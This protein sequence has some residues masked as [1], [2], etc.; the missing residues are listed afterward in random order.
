MGMLDGLLGQ[1]LSGAAGQQRGDDDALSGMSG[2]GRAPGGMGGLGGLE[3]LLGGAAGGGGM[4][5]AAGA[6]GLMGVLLQMLQQNGGLGGLLSQFQ[7]AGY[8][9]QA[10]SWVSNGQ[11]QAIS[12]DILSKVLGSGQLDQIAQQLGMS[13]GQAADQMASALPDVVNHMT[14]Q[15]SLPSNGDDLVSRALEML[16]R[17]GR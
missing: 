9:D 14:P 1:I 11:N 12:G 2:M 5:G 3:S 6:G 7:Q 13:R 15:G 4:A 8:G 10:N 17:G 16:N